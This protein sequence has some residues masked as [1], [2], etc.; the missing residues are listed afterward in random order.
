MV[1]VPLYDTLGSDVVDHILHE[2]RVQVVLCDAPNVGQLL[3]S[4]RVPPDLKIVI[5]VGN[6]TPEELNRANILRLYLCSLAS[7][8][9]RGMAHPRPPSPPNPSDVATVCYTS[10]T[11]GMP[12]G[13]L[14]THANLLAD[15]AGVLMTFK[16]TY[17]EFF[18]LFVAV[19]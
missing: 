5:K 18:F 9:D 7:V 14:L 13:A 19:G 8:E 4:T 17:S 16:V 2:A 11:T 1:T 15:A 3:Q 12:K 6:P 10:G